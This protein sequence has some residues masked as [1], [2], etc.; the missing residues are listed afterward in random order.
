M[1]VLRNGVDLNLFRETDRDRTRRELNLSGPVVI[2]VGH[3]IPRKGHE[4]VIEAI[5]LIPD[6]QLLICGEGPKRLEL[7]R[8]AQ[9]FGVAD[10][11]RFLGLIAHE[12]LKSLLQCRRRSRSSFI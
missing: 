10:R 8:C 1:E 2:S 9:Q 11:V 6:A 3:L 12:N 4:L 7:E 5:S